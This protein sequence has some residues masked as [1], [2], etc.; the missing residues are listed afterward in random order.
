MNVMRQTTCLVVNPI[1]AALFYCTPAGLASDPMK[2]PAYFV[3]IKLVGCL[4]LC[5]WLGPPGST[6]GFLFLRRFSVD[7]AV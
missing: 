5:L 7:F 1:T 2:A 6:V 4:M 3:L